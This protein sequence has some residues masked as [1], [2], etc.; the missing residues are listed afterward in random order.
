MNL[1][2]VDDEKV[3]GERSMLPKGRCASVETAKKA[4]E[5]GFDYILLIGNPGTGVMNDKIIEIMQILKKCGD[6]L[7]IMAGKM[8]GVGS[9]KEGGNHIICIDV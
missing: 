2:P 7:I 9:R 4:I 6:Q 5:L 8:H 3:L 1:E